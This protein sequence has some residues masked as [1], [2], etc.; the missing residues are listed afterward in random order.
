MLFAAKKNRCSTWNNRK[1]EM[2]TLEIFALRIEELG[3]RLD[4]RQIEAFERYLAEIKRVNSQLNLVSHND[5]QR[6]PTRHFLDSVMP[7]LKG[8]LPQGDTI[9]DIGSGGGFP[10]IPLG[11][12]HP[13]TSFLLVE[14]NQK[15]C[16]FLRQVR[17]VLSLKNVNVCNVRIEKLPEFDT[18]RLYDGAVA[19]AVS[20]ISQLAGWCGCVLKPGGKLICYKG[21][22]P[23]GEIESAGEILVAE[24]LV[25]EG[26]HSY[27]EGRRDSPTLVV[28][29]KTE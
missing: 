28:L 14:S 24:N 9:I 15:K 11:I 16:T 6:I 19:R 10:G 7:S 23:E 1:H 3:H 26:T 20:S 29:R 25:W 22:E 21:P 8:I 12:L 13:D 5:L 27:D 17:R 2:E 4:A 18:D